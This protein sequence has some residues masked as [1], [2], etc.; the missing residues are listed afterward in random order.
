MTDP[1]RVL[2]AD[3]HPLFREGVGRSLSEDPDLDVVAEADA[4]SD[5]VAMAES[6][7]PDI[8][9]LDIRMGEGNEGLRAA[10]EIA[11]RLPE[12]RVVMLTVSGE[13]EDLLTAFKLGARG[14]VLKGVSSRELRR[15]LHDV[16]NGKVYVSPELAVDILTD[17]TSSRAPDPL[18]ELTPRERRVLELVAEGL[19]NKEVGERLHLSEKTVKHYMTQV[20]DKLQVRNRVEAVS[21]LRS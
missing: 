12:T 1:V 8:A 16:A 7:R 15:I 13:E 20:L 6:L 18:Q 11:E 17:L 14:Y 9:L 3:D 4:P 19:T 10:G 5:A 21:K 2:I